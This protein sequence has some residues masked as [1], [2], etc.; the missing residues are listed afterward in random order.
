MFVVTGAGRF[1]RVIGNRGWLSQQLEVP[2]HHFAATANRGSRSDLC[3]AW[4][5]HKR[6]SS[7]PFPAFAS[8]A[9]SGCSVVFGRFLR[10]SR[11][12]R[13]RS[14]LA[15]GCLQEGTAKDR[16]SVSRMSSSS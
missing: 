14:G 10:S 3:F 15:L 7:R 5:H 9:V 13:R 16:R 12:A 8:V 11:N 6:P 4:N 1:E 2:H